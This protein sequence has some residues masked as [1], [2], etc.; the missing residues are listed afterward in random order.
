VVETAC[1]ARPVTVADAGRTGVD[2]RGWSALPL[3]GR[4]TRETGPWLF[5]CEPSGAW[6]SSGGVADAQ[7]VPVPL[8]CDGAWPFDDGTLSGVVIDGDAVLRGIGAAPLERLL[9]EASRVTSQ[10]DNVLVACTHRRVPRHL[11]AWREYGR[12]SAGAWRRAAALAGVATRT[13]GSLRLDGP[14]VT[15]LTLA[16]G[17]AHGATAGAG[18]ADRLVLQMSAARQVDPVVVDGMIADVA[19]AAGTVLTVD[20]IA[21]RKIGKT[22]VFLSGSD[23]RRYIMRIA[24]SPIALARG[25]RN[26]ETLAALHRSTLPPAITARVPAAVLQGAHAGYTVFLETCLDG[27]AGPAAAGPR[28]PGGWTRAAVEF[29]TDLHAATRRMTLL[30]APRVAALVGEPMARITGACADP[31]A[32]DVLHKVEAICRGT[33]EGLTLPLVQ[34]QGDFTESNCLFGPD[35]A[36]TAV[37][38]WEV[39]VPDGL[40]LMDLLQFMPVPAPAGP[41]R[42]WPHFDAWLALLQEPGRVAADPVMGP[43]LR[44]LGVP[45][46]SVPALILLQ[47]VTHVA[48]RIEARADDQRWLRLRVWQPLESLGRTLRD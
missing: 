9:T 42:R 3:L 15:D 12:Q 28:S 31:A 19:R 29:I 48:D 46:A 22:A 18:E 44:T 2:L 37:V 17:H 41:P 21:V 38:D 33:L 35:G 45:A 13:V 10:H 27:T 47:W 6:L 34:T 23:G 36:L 24:R 39:A 43:Y 5:V 8:R 32:R 11:S 25:R 30:D 14:R 7:F 16:S 1:S 4:A 20:R 26:F 40:P